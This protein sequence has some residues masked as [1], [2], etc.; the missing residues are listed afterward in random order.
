MFAPKPHAVKNLVEPPYTIV[1]FQFA[2]FWRR[3]Q[4]IMYLLLLF[5]SLGTLYEPSNGTKVLTMAKRVIGV[6]HEGR[7][8][9]RFRTDFQQ[10]LSK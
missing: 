6:S 10:S 4:S 2:P 5:A 9:I 1:L 3:V 8:C 7:A